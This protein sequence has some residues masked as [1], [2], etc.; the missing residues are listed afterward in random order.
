MLADKTQS[1]LP[2]M[3][4]RDH[5]ADASRQ[6]FLQQLRR[7]QAHEAG[8]R[9]GEDIESVHKM[10]VAVR[11][12]R[13][14]LRLA[15]DYFP[16][17]TV[18]RTQTRL[19]RI[20]R[21]LGAIRD[22]DVLILDLQQ[23]SATLPPESQQH[24]NALVRRLDRRRSKRRK[25]LNAFLDS[26]RYERALRQLD[27]FA[28]KQT[29]RA[30]RPL[31]P[32]EPQELRHVLPSLLHQRLAIVSAY[33]AVLS[34][35]D[36]KRLHALR[37]ECKRLRYAIEFFAP[38]LGASAAS[39]LELVTAMQD[40]LG[41][42]NDIAV[43]V[44]RLQKLKKLPPEQALIVEGYIASRNEELISHRETFYEGWT[45]LNTRAQRRKF[46]DALLVLR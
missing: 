12:M 35:A 29:R 37:V 11:R 44:S 2:A 19:R 8:S 25:R 40:T 27:K 22:L 13:S 42:I 17:K 30:G 26:K 18:A 3:Q 20:A 1:D 38:V 45:R 43:F 33:D 16:D 24:A 39:F 46:S 34:A 28:C 36:D 7:M 14:L 6:I 21:A 9:T 41:R 4:G 10:R 23:F 32:H 15:G 31:R 5:V